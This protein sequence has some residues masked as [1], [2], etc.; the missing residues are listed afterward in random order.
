MRTEKQI[1]DVQNC[2][3]VFDD[4]RKKWNEA[5]SKIKKIPEDKTDLS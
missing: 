3:G 5:V 4:V 1:D 2:K